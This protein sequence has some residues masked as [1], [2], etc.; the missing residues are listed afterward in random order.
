VPYYYDGQ[1]RVDWDLHK[2]GH[3]SVLAL[4]SSDQLRVVNTPADMQSSL[5]LNSSIDFFR[6][7]GNYTRPLA[8]DLKLTISP[9]F[10]RDKVL[11]AG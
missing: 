4:I 7:I 8:G 10:G 2:D 3:A 6:V 5:K 9:A 11:F 1:A